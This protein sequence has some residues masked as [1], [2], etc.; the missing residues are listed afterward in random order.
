[1]SAMF[2]IRGCSIHVSVGDE[3]SIAAG[4]LAMD[5]MASTTWNYC[6]NES[7]HVGVLR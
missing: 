1:M 3:L 4:L 2:L 7:P 6:A 5:A